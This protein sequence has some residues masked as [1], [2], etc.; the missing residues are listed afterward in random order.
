MTG[1]RWTDL[2]MG[3]FAP[4]F[5]GAF[6]ATLFWWALRWV[7]SHDRW[8]LMF[9]RG[10]AGGAIG[11]GI[12][13]LA[14]RSWLYAGACAVSFAIALAIRWWRKN[15]R[16]VRALLGAKSRVL[17]DALTARMPQPRTVPDSA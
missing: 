10:W 14:H 7:R 8:F 6:C 17:R 9:T 2:L 5:W 15:R 13:G 4:P 3:L 11:G 16:R 1:Q 12:A